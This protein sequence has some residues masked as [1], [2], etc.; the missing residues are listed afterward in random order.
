MTPDEIS[1]AILALRE[2]V[3]DI[4]L[5]ARCQWCK[6]SLADKLNGAWFLAHTLKEICES[7]TE[8]QS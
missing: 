8:K 2:R 1:G 3:L 5:P 4:E 7:E 6:E